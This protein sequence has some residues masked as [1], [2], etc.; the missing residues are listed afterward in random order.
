VS[1]TGLKKSKNLSRNQQNIEV[2][3]L[4]YL[5]SDIESGP[6]GI[7][8]REITIN[9]REGYIRELELGFNKNEEKDILA[10]RKEYYCSMIGKNGKAINMVFS[11]ND[12]VVISKGVKLLNEDVLI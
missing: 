4:V 9:S 7:V 3:D 1:K 12:L 10:E 6:I 8:L 5:G 2:G 11:E